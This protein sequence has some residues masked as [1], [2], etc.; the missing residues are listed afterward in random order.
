MDPVKPRQWRDLLCFVGAEGVLNAKGRDL[1][2]KYDALVYNSIHN[3]CV[4]KQRRRREEQSQCRVSKGRDG[5]GKREQ[6]K[7]E[8][9]LILAG[10][11]THAVS[12]FNA[13]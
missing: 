4:M 3:A 2:Y 10:Q 13:Q 11:V 5:K 9:V 8:G 1:C 7:L 6:E 12:M